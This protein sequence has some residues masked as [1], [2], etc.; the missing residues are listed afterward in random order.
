[1]LKACHRRLWTAVAFS[2]GFAVLGSGVSAQAQAVSDAQIKAL[3]NQI[4]QLQAT[5]KQLEAQQEKSS[6]E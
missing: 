2:A 5:V 1:M 6:A 4:N 3:Q